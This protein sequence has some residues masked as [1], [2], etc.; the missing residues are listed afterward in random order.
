MD[1]NPY[2]PPTP[3]AYPEAGRWQ[4][5]VYLARQL[6][7]LRSSAFAQRESVKF[8]LSGRPFMEYGVVFSAMTGVHDRY[9]A[10]LPL[11]IDD[12]LHRQRNAREAARVLRQLVARVD[13]LGEALRERD[14]VVSMVPSYGQLDVELCRVVI[15]AEA[16]CRPDESDAVP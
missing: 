3:L 14:L 9:F 11:A 5:L 15:P 1:L 7:G 16:W 2:Q 13:G 4:R 12:E 8:L 6:L 10:A